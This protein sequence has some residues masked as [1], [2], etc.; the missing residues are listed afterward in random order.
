[1]AYYRKAEEAHGAHRRRRRWRCRCY[2]L[3]LSS[4]AA[5]STATTSTSGTRVCVIGANVG[6]ELFD[7]VIAARRS[8]SQSTA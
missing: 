3:E 2:R 6:R 5:S 8:T 4:R 1:M 7:G